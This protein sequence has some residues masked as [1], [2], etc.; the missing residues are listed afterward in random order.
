MEERNNGFGQV[1]LTI[2]FPKQTPT[3]TQEREPQK[4][5]SL[6][7]HGCHPPMFRSLPKQETK[8]HSAILGRMEASD[9]D[10]FQEAWT[11]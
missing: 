7:V 4:L 10:R 2:E 6:W 8:D 5:L 1:E 11:N 9:P 3:M